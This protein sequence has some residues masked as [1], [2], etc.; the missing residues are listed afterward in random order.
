MAG[1]GG[2]E[3]VSN[4]NEAINVSDLEGQIIVG[5]YRLVQYLSGGAFGAV[6]R[7]AH[8]A[9][10][11]ELREVAV[12]IAKR[13]MTDAEARRVFCDALVMARLADTAPDIALRQ[14]FVTVYDAGRCPEGGPLAGHP[15]VVMEWVSG[16]S[17]A[18][19]LRPGPF[20]LKRAS[21]Y[22]D[23][24]LRA[25]A[26]MH[27]GVPGAGGRQEPLV[28]RDLKPGNI[29]VH[30]T[31]EGRDVVKLTDFGLAVKVDTLLGWVSSGGDL[32]YLAPES[33]SHN[34]SSPQSDVYMLALVF[35]EMLT[36]QN[37]F[38]HVGVTVETEDE[39]QKCDELRR[40][41]WDARRHEDFP[42][43]ESH[44][45]IH[46]RPA[47]GLVIRRALAAD[48]NARPYKNAGE[49]YEAWQR[50][51]AGEGPP[52]ESPW[53]VVQRLANEA[54]QCFAMLNSAQGQALLDE[55]MQLNR[56]RSLVPARYIIGRTY[57][58]AVER[59]IEVGQ[60]QEAGRVAME[61]Y[62]CRRCQSTCKGLAQYYHAMNSPLAE[63][64]E[65]ESLDCEDRE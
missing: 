27:A 21:E 3:A 55:A 38:R 35:Y 37:P 53:E 47:L 15:Y 7:A 28:H 8:L 34:I 20:P 62:R 49:L 30:R 33:F 63:S 2:D 52:P 42:L 23:Q 57:R 10:E 64:L 4:G 13:P 6:Y 58:L 43:L 16:G 51:K 36:K 39:E 5:K 11:L 25:L 44:P 18:D 60:V 29:L 65:K 14:H 40:L 26:F 1:E 41:H 59:M 54:E 61:G 45:E 24:M 46:R 48:M 19:C 22:F 56:D 12:K 32:A 9:H 50:A 31:A 17:L